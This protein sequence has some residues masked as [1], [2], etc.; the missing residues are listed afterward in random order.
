M[1]K[2][3]FRAWHK[4]IKKML[5][6]EDIYSLLF[7]NSESVN[8]LMHTRYEDIYVP[9]EAEIMQFT[10]IKDS[11][12]QELYDGDIIYVK[13]TRDKT[14][15]AG[16]YTVTFDGAAFRAENCTEY[17]YLFDVWAAGDVFLLGNI[18]E[19]PELLEGE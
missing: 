19:N 3:K 17:E 11:N 1:R 6:P 10:D 15:R 13:P 8:G 4:E 12:Q 16:Q 18:Y 14:V 9:G 5:H 2:I 7:Y